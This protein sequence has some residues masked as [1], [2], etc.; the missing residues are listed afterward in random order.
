M[1]LSHFRLTLDVMKL[2][3][4]N[5]SKPNQTII[6]QTQNINYHIYIYIY[7]YNTDLCKVIIYAPLH[8]INI[9]LNVMKLYNSI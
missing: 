6:T 5:I 2:T 4:L 3:I 8:S 9:M 1:L 7:I